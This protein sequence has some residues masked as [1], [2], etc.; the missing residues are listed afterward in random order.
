VEARDAIRKRKCV[1]IYRDQPVSEKIVLEILDCARWAQTALNAQSWE[2]IIVTERPNKIRL[3]EAAEQEWVSAAP[4]V[5]VVASNRERIEFILKKNS[6][7]LAIMEISAAVQNMQVAARSLG[8]GTCAVFMFNREKVAQIVGT[9]EN[10][11]P[12]A[13]V[14]I[15]YSKEFPENSRAALEDFLHKEKFGTPL[16]GKVPAEYNRKWQRHPLLHLLK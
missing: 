13:I 8:L 5:I 7:D 4:V 3:A 12:L 2:F 14:P 1:K 15:G 16:E 9:P 6:Q 10:V 11:I